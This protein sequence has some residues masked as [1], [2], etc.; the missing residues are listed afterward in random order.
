MGCTK[1]KQETRTNVGSP[2]VVLLT[3]E[4]IVKSK[5]ADELVK[6]TKSTVF[7][8]QVGRIAFIPRVQSL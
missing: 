6:I 3:E 2:D 8:R 5:C 7:E 1:T 4:D